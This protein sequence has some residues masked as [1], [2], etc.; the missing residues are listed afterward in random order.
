MRMEETIKK[1]KRKIKDRENG[2]K[3]YAHKE[4]IRVS[5]EDDESHVSSHLSDVISSLSQSD[6]SYIY[7]IYMRKEDLIILF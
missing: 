2:E 3:S 7:I 1:S 4:K 5:K 6:P